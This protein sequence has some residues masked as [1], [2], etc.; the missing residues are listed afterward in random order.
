MQSP[1][2]THRCFWA[3]NFP[4]LRKLLWKMHFMLVYFSKNPWL[5]CYKTGDLAQGVWEI[6]RRGKASW[7]P[8]SPVCSDPWFT[9]LLGL[10]PSSSRRG[11][12]LFP[13]QGARRRRS[14]HIH[15]F[16]RHTEGCLFGWGGLTWLQGSKLTN[17]W[18]TI[19]REFAEQISLKAS[20][21]I[22]ALIRLCLPYWQPTPVFLPRESHGHRSLVGYR[23]ES[24]ESQSQ[25]RLKRLSSQST[26]KAVPASLLTS[27]CSYTNGISLLFLRWYRLLPNSPYIDP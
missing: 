21:W 25:T 17:T 26:H 4:P 2:I 9:C 13:C 24:R 15:H 6:S 22:F 14:Q 1:F 5:N 27:H 16:F 8:W 3:M 19:F 12:W 11:F 10:W 7:H 20:T 18:D 23:P